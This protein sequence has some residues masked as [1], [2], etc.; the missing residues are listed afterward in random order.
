M[1]NTWDPVN[2]KPLCPGA[3]VRTKVAFSLPNPRMVSEYRVPPTFERQASSPCNA[4]FL[5][6]KEE[7]TEESRALCMLAKRREFFHSVLALANPPPYFFF[8]QSK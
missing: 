1:R 8:R 6:L 4:R 2:W 5:A 3:A 7:A